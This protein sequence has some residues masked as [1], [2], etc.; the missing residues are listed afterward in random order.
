[1]DREQL[2]S[3]TGPALVAVPAIEVV[4]LTL[5]FGS[6][7]VLE[8]VDMKFPACAVTSLLGP[9]GSGKTTF[10][11]TLNRMNDKVYG[12]RYSGDVL[13]GGRSIFKERDLMEF[14]RSIG[15]LFQ[16]PNPFPMSIVDNVLAGVRA[17]RLVPRKEFKNV[18]E[19][20]LREVGLWNAVKDRL[21]DSP[22][23]LSGGQQQLLCLARTLAVDP[24]VLLLDEPT[25]SLDPTT[26]EKIEQLFRSLSNRL[27]V[28]MVTHDLAQAARVGDRTALFYDG[29]L[30]EEGPTEQLFLS[31]KNEQ[32]A[33]YISGLFGDRKLL[34]VVVGSAEANSGKEK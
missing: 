21:D 5:G 15:M 31:P 4:N 30:V 1:M 13:M 7:T 25:S 32:T 8:G 16:R 9:T 18:A 12:Y 29:R 26:T 24:D 28:I 2:D 23:R 34:G 20:R 3:E 22:F 33:R 11:R 19:S 17:H 6:K 14:R 10:L 27:T